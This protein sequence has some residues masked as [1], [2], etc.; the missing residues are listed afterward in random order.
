MVKGP[1]A[2]VSFERAMPHDLASLKGS[3]CGISSVWGEPFDTGVCRGHGH[4]G[5]SREGVLWNKY[6]PHFESIVSC[7]RGRGG[8]AYILAFCCD[9]GL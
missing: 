4:S 8:V 3:I 5:H 7:S 2:W 6:P 9:S 1:R